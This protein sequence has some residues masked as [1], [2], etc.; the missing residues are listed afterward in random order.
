M[1]LELR[2]KML[3][4][5]KRQCEKE[6]EMLRKGEKK[7]M[8]EYTETCDELDRIMKSGKSYRNSDNNS[9]MENS[10]ATGRR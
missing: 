8:E 1:N 9:G 6:I 2:V 3:E 5:R 10:P 4:K 7:K